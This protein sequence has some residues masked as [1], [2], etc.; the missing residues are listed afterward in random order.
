MK[1]CEHYNEFTW[2]E[3]PLDE[4]SDGTL[5]TE[6]ECKNAQGWFIA[7][8]GGNK[9]LCDLPDNQNKELLAKAKE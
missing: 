1:R 7:I 9:K 4:E 8:C 6:Y 2:G 5:Y 3:P